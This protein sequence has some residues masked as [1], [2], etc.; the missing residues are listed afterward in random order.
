MTSSLQIVSKVFPLL[1]ER[2]AGLF[3]HDPIFRELCDDYEACF[4]ALT[5][6]ESNERLRRE[7]S[8]LRLRLETEGVRGSAAVPAPAR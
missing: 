8:A 3:E 7:Y 1:R 6:K 5:R 4:L 2:V